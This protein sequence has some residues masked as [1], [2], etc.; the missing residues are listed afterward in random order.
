[1]YSKSI[2]KLIKEFSKLPTVGPRTAGRFVFYLINKGE[3]ESKELIKAI[4]EA[5]SKIKICSLCFKSFEGE[6]E[7]CAVCADPRR[8]KNLICIVEK[9]MDLEAL[10]ATHQF[11]GFYFILGGLL[12]RLN[13]NKEE[14]EARLQNLITRIKNNEVRPRCEVI[15][16]LNPT[17]EG[18]NTALW[19]RRQ[20]EPLGVKI[21]QLGRGLPVGGELEYADE[22]TLSS[23][24]NNR[25]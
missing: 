23:A 19:L 21:T 3:A 14:L 24:L 17:A 4:E 8:D 10:E 6:G 20:L 11:K 18:Q 22:Q 15:L 7:L 5:Q 9:E 16:A 2:E 1:M 13:K 12:S 25:S